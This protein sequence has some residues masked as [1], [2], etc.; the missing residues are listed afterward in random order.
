[1]AGFENKIPIN[2]NVFAGGDGNSVEDAPI[3]YYRFHFWK[4][5]EQWKGM[6]VR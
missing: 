2:R 1:M 6:R 5:D 4:S 3:G